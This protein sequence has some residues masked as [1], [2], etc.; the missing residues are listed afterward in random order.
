MTFIYVSEDIRDADKNESYKR[1]THSDS[2]D[3][4]PSVVL[5]AADPNA[6]LR[7]LLIE[8]RR[9][10]LSFRFFSALK[11]GE[12]GEATL[13]LTFQNNDDT[14]AFDNFLVKKGVTLEP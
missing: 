9:E 11:R 6:G 1:Y 7:K 8:A 5:P 3:Y 14:D 12:N 4:F 13:H 2:L 10:G